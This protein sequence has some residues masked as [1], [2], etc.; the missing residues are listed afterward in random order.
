[1]GLSGLM[2]DKEDIQTER[3]SGTKCQS[4]SG[5]KKIY[6]QKLARYWMLKPKLTEEGTP[7]GK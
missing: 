2:K 7:M 4:P 1:M 5:V 6:L 3:W